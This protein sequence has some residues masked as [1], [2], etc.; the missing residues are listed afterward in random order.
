MRIKNQKDFFAGLLVVALG[1]FFVGF[2]LQYKFGTSAKMGPSYFPTV[3]GTISILL[4]I[5]IS[6]RGLCAKAMEERIAK[7][8][9]PAL[10]LILGPIVLFG[11]LLKKLGLI[12]SLLILVAGSSYADKGF[13]WRATLMNAAVLIVI[14]LVVFVWGLKL[15]FQLWPS[16]IGN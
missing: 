6:V 3:V 2:G 10:L 12:L 13:R 1:L 8:N 5:I 14:C 11:L 7:F 9:W 16:F 4:G 15:Q